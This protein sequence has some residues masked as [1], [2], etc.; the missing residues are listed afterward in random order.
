MLTI[1]DVYDHSVWS[2]GAANGHSLFISRVC[3]HSRQVFILHM[4][5]SPL[6]HILRE[7]LAFPDCLFQDIRLKI[8]LR[9]LWP[10]VLLFCEFW[11]HYITILLY[12]YITI[13]L[14]YYITILLYYYIIILLYYYITI[15]LYY[16]II[17][18]LYYYIIVLQCYYITI[19]LHYYLIILLY[20]YITILLYYYIT[21]LLYYLITLIRHSVSGILWYHSFNVEHLVTGDHHVIRSLYILCNHICHM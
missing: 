19:L 20:Y 5:L 12:Y 11:Q 3:C 9:E 18:L 16:Y 1:V 15:L 17:I 6:P 4:D 2:D 7:L 10:F 14:Y 21:I 13:L 8:C